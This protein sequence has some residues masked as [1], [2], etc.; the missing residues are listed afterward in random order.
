M[1]GR[2]T[3]ATCR[4][5]LALCLFWRPFFV[6]DV[7][8]RSEDGHESAALVLVQTII[9]VMNVRIACIIRRGGHW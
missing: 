1:Y 8:V 5:I 2:G 6:A 7:S 9:A 3:G 4:F